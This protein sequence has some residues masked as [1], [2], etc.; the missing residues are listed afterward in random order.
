MTTRRCPDDRS[1]GSNGTTDDAGN[2]PSPDAPP[3]TGSTR[4]RPGLR[5]LGRVLLAASMWLPLGYVAALVLAESP[6]DSEPGRLVV[7]ALEPTLIAA[8]LLYWQTRRRDP[9]FRQL[10]L[11]TLLCHA[12]FWALTAATGWW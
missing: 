2:D 4:S 9:A 5:H 8:P 12:V 6:H 3:E 7:S 1:T 11:T 10:A